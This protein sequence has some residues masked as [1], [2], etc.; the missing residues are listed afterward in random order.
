MAVPRPKDDLLTFAPRP[1]AFVSA[2]VAQGLLP[3]P[4]AKGQGFGFQTQGGEVTGLATNVADVAK[5]A[6]QFGFQAQA[7][8]PTAD[9][10]LNLPR[11]SVNTG[12]DLSSA[13]QA[14]LKG[15]RV[16]Q[17]SSPLATPAQ[18]AEQD[19][20][21]KAGALKDAQNFAL[22]LRGAPAQIAADSRAEVERIR[23]AGDLAVTNAKIGS[24]EKIQRAKD[25]AAMER[26]NL[27]AAVAS[28]N[29]QEQIKSRERIA[30]NEIAANVSEMVAQGLDVGSPKW[31]QVQD[32]KLQQLQA[33]G[34]IQNQA[35][36]D[37]IKRKSYSDLASDAL[38]SLSNFDTSDA[39]KKRARD[40][41]QSSLEV[42]NAPAE[43]VQQ[44]T[45]TPQGTEQTT[46]VATPAGGAVEQTTTSDIN[47]DGNLSPDE[48]LYD[49]FSNALKNTTSEAKRIQI[50]DA[51]KQLKER[52]L[53]GK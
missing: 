26:E 15:D 22:K 44:T 34:I 2:D 45:V 17:A 52:I 3:S 32:A 20:Q 24:N 4:L 41:I 37:Q 5:F 35:Q 46:A 40:I 7:Q 36:A 51:M 23:A 39:D 49:N 10:L 16:S 50:Q 21:A 42:L 31:Q 14:F 47:G 18:K 53:G 29:V 11:P 8:R 1:D 25:I 43:G 9:A 28:N 6:P 33:E 12:P 27:K 13:Q 48:Q 38:R 19:Q 30:Q